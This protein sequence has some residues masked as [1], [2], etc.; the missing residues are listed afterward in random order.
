MI[1]LEIS[2]R[3]HLFSILIFVSLG[4]PDALTRKLVGATLHGLVSVGL[5]DCDQ[6]IKYRFFEIYAYFMINL[7]FSWNF[8]EPDTFFYEINLT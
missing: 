2:M 6:V 4:C 7:A 3:L 8:L 1:V 5:V